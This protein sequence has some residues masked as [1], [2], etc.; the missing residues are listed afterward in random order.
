MKMRILH[1]IKELLSFYSAGRF[2]TKKRLV[3]FV[4]TCCKDAIY[5]SDIQINNSIILGKHRFFFLLSSS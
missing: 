1:H 2:C 5:F 3:F 4:I